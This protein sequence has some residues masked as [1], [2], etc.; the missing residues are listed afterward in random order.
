[1]LSQLK[2][3][4]SLSAHQAG[5]YPGFCGV[6]QL[7]VQLYVLILVL[8]PREISITQC[9]SVSLQCELP[10]LFSNQRRE[11]TACDFVCGYFS[12]RFLSVCSDI[13]MSIY[14]KLLYWYAPV[15]VCHLAEIILASREYSYL[16]VNTNQNVISFK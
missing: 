4:P 9:S 8:C 11:I 5:A 10:R 15:D 6:K 1:M 14:V 12:F 3:V 13:R 7:R 2:S 16:S